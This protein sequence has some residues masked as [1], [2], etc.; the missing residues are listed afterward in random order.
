MN[1]LITGASSGLGR[2]MAA[3]IARRHPQA[4]LGLVARRGSELSALATQIGPGRALPLAADLLDPGAMQEVAA[5]FTAEVGPADWV[6]ANAGISAGTLG[7]DPDD[8]AAFSRI[9]ALNLDAMARSFAPFVAGMRARGGGR[10]VG[11][12]SVAGIRGL[13][14]AGAYSASKAGA[15]AYLESLR[16]ELRDTGIRVVTIAPGYIR[17]PMT[18]GNRYPMPFL[19]EADAFARRAVDAIET[20]RRWAV[21]PWQMAWV[22]RLLR[23]L[24]R[25]VYDRAFA[26]APRKAR[27]QG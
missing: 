16:V 12:A 23:V 26:R 15:I 21:I 24:P 18:A 17:T 13:P 8:L 5:R 25:P 9:V 20:G 4:R 19:M 22:A 2:A 10:L 14:G 3:E 11:I 27:A 7:G 6:I 1:V